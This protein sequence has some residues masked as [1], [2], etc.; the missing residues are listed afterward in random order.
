MPA[1]SIRSLRKS[2]LI[3]PA[4]DPQR[5]V[6]LAGVDLEIGEGEIVG[7]IGGASA[8]KTTLLLCAAGLLRRDS[9]SVYWFGARFGGGG[10]LPGVVYVSPVLTY[11]PFLT[12]R[13]VLTHHS[14]FEASGDSRR[15][16]LV[17]KLAS[18]LN[19]TLHLSRAVK[20]LDL[21]TL[22]LLAIAAAFAERPRVILFD[23]TLD[24][25]GAAAAVAHRVIKE[26]AA[27]GVTII[28]A[29]REAGA[30]APVATRFAVMESGRVTGSFTTEATSSQRYFGQ[31]G[32]PALPEL[33]TTGGLL[34][35][36]RQIAERVH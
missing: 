16:M 3:G 19:L 15:R 1:L 7:L 10:C 23:S 20:D 24:G 5:R 17:E 32:L 9:G 21:P 30:L 12:V 14:A 29:S 11:Y 35:P 25:L 27:A 31:A 33:D 26:A 22:K 2:F 34:I 8:G 4:N 18:G 6:A 13:D 36:L 28:A